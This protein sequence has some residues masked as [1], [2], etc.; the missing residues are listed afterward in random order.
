MGVLGGDSVGQD[1]A[2][3]NFRP[4]TI[5]SYLLE[6]Q[7]SFQIKTVQAPHQE[8]V[9]ASIERF[10]ADLKAG[11]LDP[12]YANPSF[13]ILLSAGSE[14][15][16]FSSPEEMEQISQT[17]AVFA[18]AVVFNPGTSQADVY[19]GQFSNGRFFFNND[20]RTNIQPGNTTYLITLDVNL[21]TRVFQGQLSAG[22][23]GSALSAGSEGSALASREL[24]QALL[25]QQQTLYAKALEVYAQ[26]QQVYQQQVGEL[27]FTV[28]NLIPLAYTETY[29]RLMR[30][31]PDELTLELQAMRGL[32]KG[33]LF[34]AMQDALDRIGQRW[35][36]DCGSPVP[37]GG[38]LY[39]Q[40]S[41]D[42]GAIVPQ[43]YQSEALTQIIAAEPEMQAY[44]RAEIAKPF[45]QRYGGRS[46][47]AVL[48]ELQARYA[49][50]FARYQ[51]TDIF[52]PPD[53]VK[54]I[55]DRNPLPPP[56]PPGRS[57]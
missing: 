21:E 15:S 41:H 37:D 39:P 8:Q 35:L 57:S 22:S 29:A 11:Q 56:P 5:A 34:D 40:L 30:A 43:G 20:A 53:C 55:R 25:A 28:Q 46:F 54:P 47:D 33:L 42:F 50:S 24:N 12:Y 6:V 31:Y 16:A 44:L 18:Q 14:G 3:Q 27:T 51:W 9:T 45:S 38:S 52:A 17:G 10:E 19:K 2:I 7:D 49:E 32:P 36:A 48:A 23:E 4:H 13:S 26:R 1:L